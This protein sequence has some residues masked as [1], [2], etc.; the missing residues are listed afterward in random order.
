MIRV[1]EDVYVIGQARERKDKIEPEIAFD[2]ESPLFVVSTQP[3]KKVTRGY[4]AGFWVLSILGWLLSLGGW[5]INDLSYDI[6]IKEDFKS[7]LFITAI[8]F[9]LWVLG[10][11]LMVYNDMIR[12]RNFVRQGWSNVDVQLKRRHDLIPNLITVVKGYKEHEKDIQE[13]LA[14]L[15]SQSE[16]SGAGSEEARLR[17]IGSNLLALRE[18]H[19]ELKAQSSFLK[20]QKELADTE[21]RIALARSYYN[22]I[23]TSYNTRLQTIPDGL[24]GK[25]GFLKT[26][27]LIEAEDFQRPAIEVE[28]TSESRG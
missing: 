22:D 3:E 15:R 1:D 10:W 4:K 28:L 23:A 25:I 13:T 24:I 9:G 8:Y 20:L 6:P 12:L 27:S 26:V 17:G 19:P 14:L 21:T 2:K 18:A 7:F 16:V 5:A 11:V